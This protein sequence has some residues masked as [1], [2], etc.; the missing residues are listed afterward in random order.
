[1]LE[2]VGGFRRDAPLFLRECPP[3]ADVMADAFDDLRQVVLLASGLDP[4]RSGVEGHRGLVSCRTLLPSGFWNG[5]DECGGSSLGKDGL[6]RLSGVVQFPV[7]AWAFVWR[8]E[9]GLVE[10]LLVQWQGLLSC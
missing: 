4:S 2:E 3:V 7:P 6:G 9:D 8:V 5:R 1:M 10:K